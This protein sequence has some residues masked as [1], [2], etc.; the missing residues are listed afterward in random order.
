MRLA[1]SAI[2]AFLVLMM[3]PAEAPAQF[4]RGLG[5]LAGPVKSIL[6]HSFRRS[7]RPYAR[8]PRSRAAARRAG[9]RAVARRPASRAVVGR[10]APAAAATAAVAAQT[11]RAEAQQQAT[12]Q[13]EAFWADAPQDV[14]DYVFLAREPGLW[15]HGFGTIV[16]AMFAQPLTPRNAEQAQAGD[17][18]TQTT[19]SSGSGAPICGE[20]NAGD[21]DTL[22]KQLR[23][24]LGLAKESK[25]LAEL[26]SALLQSDS[27][28]TATCPYELPAQLPERLHVMQDR[29]W[30]ARIALTKL[31]EPLQKFS[32][33][34][35]AGQRARLDR[36][37]PSERRRRASA[38][39]PPGQQCYALTQLPQ[40]W[41]ADQIARAVG[42]ENEQQEILGAL[43]ETSSNMAQ[44]MMSACPQSAPASAVAR[45][46]VALT[47]IDTMLFA[48]TNIVAPVDD[49]YRS[50][51][52]EQKP[53]LDTLRL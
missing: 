40:P 19:G 11:P 31:R 7:F 23:D 34:L 37:T 8:W 20:I 44:L 6:R 51:R 22:I 35:N 5:P 39:A 52:D 15:S 36:Q 2:A 13:S 30:S 21:I 43:S 46:D 9:P 14:F 45:L 18:D 4:G 50:L 16:G 42:P 24:R 25:D 41:P 38:S 49:F 12:L 48:A 47:W 33:G 26:R 32:D 27:E 3:T 29:L 1:L 53:R 17:A 10:A 28:I